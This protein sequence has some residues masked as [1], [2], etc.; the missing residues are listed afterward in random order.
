MC[1]ANSVFPITGYDELELEIGI[2]PLLIEHFP[3]ATSVKNLYHFAQISYNREFANFDNSAEVNLE[4]YGSPTPPAYDLNSVT[5]KVALLVGENDKVSTLE[6]V[7]L[8]KNRLPNVVHHM[9]IPHR[10]MN[11][12]DFIWG[13]HMDEYLFPY[14]FEMLQKHE[15]ETY[16][17]SRKVDNRSTI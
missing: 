14:I 2:M 15:D 8:L 1:I 17:E 10:K 3:M 6:D 12:A 11:H 4:K 5:I 16:T 9:V 13:R 7:A